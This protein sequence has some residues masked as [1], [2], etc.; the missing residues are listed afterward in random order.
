MLVSAFSASHKDCAKLLVSMGEELR[1]EISSLLVEAT[2][3]A[4]TME[5]ASPSR[6]SSRS[7]ITSAIRLRSSSSTCAAA[8]AA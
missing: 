4:V 1:V 3:F 6:A 7:L 8:A 2:A 5:L